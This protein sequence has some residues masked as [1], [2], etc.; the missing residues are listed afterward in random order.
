MAGKDVG[1]GEPFARFDQLIDV[2]GA[3]SE[4]RPE[5][6]RHRRLAGRHE[7]DQVNLVDRHRPRA[8]RSS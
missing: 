1:D 4:P 3:P 7:A 8:S 5:Q 2:F 6:P